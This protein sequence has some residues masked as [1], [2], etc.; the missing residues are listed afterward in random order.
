MRLKFRPSGLFATLFV[1]SQIILISPAGAQE[2]TQTSSKI[3]PDS[4][5][6]LATTDYAEAIRALQAQVQLLTSQVNELRTDQQRDSVETARLRNELNLGK[7]ALASTTIVP[8]HS[9]EISFGESPAVPAAQAPDLDQRV[10]QLEDHQQL[11]DGRI[12]EHDQTKV[13]SGSK[14]RLR[15]SGIV[16]VNLFHTQGTVDNLDYPQIADARDPL[17]SSRTFAASLR[18]S[19]IELNVFGPD[20]AGARTSANIKFDFAGGFTNVSNGITMGL[21]RLR[22]GTIRF[23]W[24]RTSLVAGQDNLFFAPLT[25]TSLAS[26]AIPPLSYAGR[27]WSWTPQVR[28][29]HQI[30]FSES[31]SLLLQGGVLDSLTGEIPQPGYRYPT[32]G[33]QSGQP[34][35]AARAALRHRAFSREF[36]LGSGG[37]YARQNWGLNRNVNSWAFTADVM[38]PLTTRMAFSGEFYRGNAVGGLGGGIGQTI[39]LSGNI[40]DSTTTIR[41]L[42]SMGG[43]VQMKFKPKTNLEFNAALGQDNPSSADLRRFPATAQY[44]GVLRSRNLSPFFN[45]VYQVRS[46]VLFSVEYRRL[47]SYPLDTKPHKAN[48]ISLSMGYLF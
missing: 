32:S 27:L 12:A 42:D 6:S 10:A 17:Q 46:D 33:E 30:A 25:P 28:V 35:F 20:I 48:Q 13:E 29:E 11:T 22:T 8:P 1:A 38:L 47:Q 36:T 19:Q 23:D 18:Q 16:L 37:Y 41:G 31:S 34:A 21:A 15:L 9:N 40:A 24:T 39:L 45:F 43:W 5:S 4:S 26:L 14:Y 2:Q 3:S 44:Y 7:G